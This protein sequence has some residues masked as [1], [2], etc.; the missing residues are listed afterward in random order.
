MFKERGE[1]NRK[2]W[3]RK[4][5]SSAKALCSLPSGKIGRKMPVILQKNGY[6]EW[7]GNRRES[8]GREHVP[9]GTGQNPHLTSTGR[10]GIRSLL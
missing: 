9:Y 10:R 3:R 2:G 5:E 7:E 8:E 6:G 4:L 1:V